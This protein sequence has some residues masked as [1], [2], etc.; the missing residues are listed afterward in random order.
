[1]APLSDGNNIVEIVEKTFSQI[2]T[3]IVLHTGK[4]MFTTL[5]QKSN[6]CI[7]RKGIAWPQS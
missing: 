5:Q 1:M 6:L 3:S 7:P 2:T 4:L